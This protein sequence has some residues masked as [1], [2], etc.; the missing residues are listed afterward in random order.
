[1]VVFLLNVKLLHHPEN[2][3]L[4]RGKIVTAIG[5]QCNARVILI[6]ICDSLPVATYTYTILELLNFLRTRKAIVA[7]PINVAVQ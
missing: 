5:F 2:V 7:L 3:L 1:M 6:M 4:A